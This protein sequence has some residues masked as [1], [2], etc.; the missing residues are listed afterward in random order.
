MADSMS[1]ALRWHVLDSQNSNLFFS[2]YESMYRQFAETEFIPISKT[3]ALPQIQTESTWFTQMN[4]TFIL[5]KRGNRG[6]EK[7][8]VFMHKAWETKKYWP[9]KPM[10]RASVRAGV[11]NQKF[12]KMLFLEQTF[13]AKN[14]S[15]FI[16]TKNRPKGIVA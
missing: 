11:L 5:H 12:W 7:W 3:K 10:K 8:I 9:T 1:V 16:Y 13:C 2:I 14:N 15:D 6:K 4:R